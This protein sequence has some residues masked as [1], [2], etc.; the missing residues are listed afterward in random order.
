MHFGYNR[1][2]VT[3]AAPTGAG[4]AWVTDPKALGNGMP[5][6]VTRLRWLSNII[7]ATTDTVVLNGTFDGPINARSAALLMPNLITAIPPGVKITFAGKF[8]GSP[9]AL[10]GNALT[11]RTVML[12]NGAS[13]RPCVFSAVMIDALVITIYNDNNSSGSSMTWATPSQ[14]VDL[15]EVWVGEGADYRAKQDP[16]R[17]K[18]GGILQR[19]AHNNQSQAF[20][21]ENSYRSITVNIVPMAEDMVIGPNPYQDDFETVADRM[22]TQK[23]TVL[24]PMYLHRGMGPPNGQ[25]P[26]VIDS[27]TIHEQRLVRSF[28]LGCPDATI[29][30]DGN[31]DKYFT[32]PITFGES[33]P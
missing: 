23:T 7:P 12:P 29:D 28:I 26:A 15:G 31:D 2:V 19:R 8:S 20:L 10:G 30:I 3:W 13:A 1:P 21:P 5:A 32:S 14:I 17:K 6:D 18:E 9:V 22:S 25:P 4:S 33:P 16:H 24:I 11:Q 27:T